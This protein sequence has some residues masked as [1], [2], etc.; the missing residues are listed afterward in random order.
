MAKITEAETFAK[1]REQRR[2]IKE[3]VS[4][5]AELNQEIYQL[6]LDLAD[7]QADCSR[8]EDRL[9]AAYEELNGEDN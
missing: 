7:S 4:Q 5:N 1:L 6:N 2:K 8:L 9:D 3:L